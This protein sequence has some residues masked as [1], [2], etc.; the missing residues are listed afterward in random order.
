MPVILDPQHWEPW[1]D[2]RFHDD[3]LAPVADTFGFREDETLPCWRLGA[4][5]RSGR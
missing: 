4:H 5:P 2:S 3:G 1:L